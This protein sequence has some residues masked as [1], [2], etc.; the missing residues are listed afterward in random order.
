MTFTPILTCLTQLRLMDV[1]IKFLWY[2]NSKWQFLLLKQMKYYLAMEYKLVMHLLIICVSVCWYWSIYL[3]E[4]NDWC[5]LC[6]GYCFDLQTV[7]NCHFIS[8]WCYIL[9]LNE[10]QCNSLFC[11]LFSSPEPVVSHPSIWP[12][13]WL[14]V[15][16]SACLS[17]NFSYFRLLLQNHWANFNQTWHKAS[18]GEGDSSLFKWRT[19]PFSIGRL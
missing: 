18:L 13:D 14:S 6:L 12:S 4:F 8:K 16:L 10:I 5:I 15:C 9:W 17:V 7:T 1:A 11:L 3:W 19:K 2:D